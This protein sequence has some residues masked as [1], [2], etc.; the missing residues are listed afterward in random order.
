MF[1]GEY[2]HSV[3]AK[4]R[5]I[6]P[7]K[8]REQLGNEFVVTKGL[9]GCLFVYSLEEWHRIEEDFSSQVQQTVKWTSREELIFRRISVNMQE[10]TRKSYQWVCSAEWKYGAGSAI[11]KAVMWMIW[12]KL[13]SIWQ[14]SGLESDKG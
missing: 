13:Q 8:F 3:D 7:S 6:V 14:N 5:L 12:T 2:N 9:D 11:W 10:L 4:G 1:M